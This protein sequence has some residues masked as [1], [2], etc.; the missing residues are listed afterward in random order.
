MLIPAISP[1]ALDSKMQRLP[2]P[3]PTTDGD[4]P[5]IYMTQGDPKDFAQRRLIVLYLAAR[6]YAICDWNRSETPLCLGLQ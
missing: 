3:Q 4:S 1:Y 6:L 2:L 5:E